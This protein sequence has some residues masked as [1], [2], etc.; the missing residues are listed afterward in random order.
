METKTRLMAVRESNHKVEGDEDMDGNRANLKTMV[1]G[2]Y[3]LQKIRIQ[4]GNRL[5]ANFRA[6]LGLQPSDKESELE[7]KEQH[8]LDMLR[9][10]YKL[11]TD[12]VATFPRKT[13][14]KGD[15]VI[16]DYTDLCLCAEYFEIERVEKDHFKRLE[17][18]VGEFAL[19]TMFLEGV[20]GIGPAMAGVII[21]EIDIHLSKYPSS[22]WKYAGL[23]VAEDGAGRSRRKEH[24][25]ER[26]YINKDGKPSTR[27]S[28]T[29]NQ[30]LKTKMV[31]VLGGSFLKAGGKYADIYHAYKHRLECHAKYGLENDKHRIAE[32]KKAGWTRFSPKLHRHN[33]A[34]RYMI[35]M[36]LIDLHAAW[37]AIE[38]YPP[39][40]VYAEA[41]LGLKHEQGQAA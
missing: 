31:G 26:E 2:A 23:D 6:K 32:A 16:S 29:Y 37:R 22:L 24:L 7:E 30:F 40:P 10:R 18:E 13:T 1:R 5:T 17:K 27:Q 33:M 8:I 38:G 28:I 39:T 12:G 9:A 11:L 19:W 15:G 41:K 4:V 36:F 14:F 25:V 35:K 34:I 20:R 21:S 3:D